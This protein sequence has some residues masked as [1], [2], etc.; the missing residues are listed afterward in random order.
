MIITCHDFKQIELSSLTYLHELHFRKCSVHSVRATNT[1][2]LSTIFTR[3]ILVLL[4][5]PNLLRVLSLNWYVNMSDKYWSHECD[6]H[7]QTWWHINY[8]MEYVTRGLI[9][10]DQYLSDMM[11]YQSSCNVFYLLIDIASCLIIIVPWMS[12]LRTNWDI[13]KNS[14]RICLRFKS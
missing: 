4:P 1:W 13:R 14:W 12:N 9:S 3:H 7:Y 10:C 2:K 6:N 11:T 5:P 8:E